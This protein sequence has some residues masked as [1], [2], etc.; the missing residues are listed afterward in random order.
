MEAIVRRLNA[1]YGFKL[2]EEEIK[3][4]ARHA[5]ESNRLFQ[6]LYEVDLTDVMPLMKVDKRKPK[7]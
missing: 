5:E 3:L 6:G 1:E 2:T 7:P 4:I